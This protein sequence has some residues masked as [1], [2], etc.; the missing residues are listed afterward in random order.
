MTLLLFTHTHTHRRIHTQTAAT[1]GVVT[2][3]GASSDYEDKCLLLEKRLEAAA[4]LL[5]QLA[6]LKVPARIAPNPTLKLCIL[7]TSQIPPSRPEF[8]FK[9]Y[10]TL[11]GKRGNPI[12]RNEP[13]F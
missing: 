3:L 2:S 13:V 7:K 9:I 6:G 4:T 11:S 1:A 5:I 8:L 12:L 10:Q